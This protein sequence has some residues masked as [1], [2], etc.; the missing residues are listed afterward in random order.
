MKVWQEQVC[1]KITGLTSEMGTFRHELM[2]K[3]SIG[4]HKE[5][6]LKVDDYGER[7][8]ILEVKVKDIIDNFSLESFYGDSKLYG[9][10]NVTKPQEPRRTL[11]AN[12][13]DDITNTA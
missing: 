12:R 5:V 2:G 9:T 10:Y 7:V 6:E 3:V 1:Q 8:V 13:Q 11:S 4:E